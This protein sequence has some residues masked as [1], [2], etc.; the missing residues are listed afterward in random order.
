MSD[1]LNTL[2]SP[3]PL[4]ILWINKFKMIHLAGMGRGMLHAQVDH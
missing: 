2:A 3:D 1:L 4:G